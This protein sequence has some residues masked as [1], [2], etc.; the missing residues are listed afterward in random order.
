MRVAVPDWKGRISPV[1]DV[2][3]Q[4]LV[5]DFGGGRELQRSA[6]RLEPTL[7]PLRVDGLARLG[8][9]VLL[10]GGISAPLLRMLEARSIRVIP[11]V[12]G[13][14]DQV[15]QGYLAGQLTDDRF[16]MPG[17]RGPGGRRY[18]GGRGGW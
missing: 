18:R 15:L 14:V 7:L 3:R 10:C 4:L 13:D 5:V 17:W 11:G 2:A 6:E 12:S 8:V 1:F 16:A 9:N